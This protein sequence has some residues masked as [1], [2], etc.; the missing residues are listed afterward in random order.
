MIQSYDLTTTHQEADVILVQQCYKLVQS[1][2]P[3][4]VIIIS[5][6]SDVFTLACSYFPK[7]N[8]DDT[9]PIEI[10]NHAKL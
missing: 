10:T 7:E 3:S 6:D 5:D 1:G 4:V 8:L 9:V 2:I